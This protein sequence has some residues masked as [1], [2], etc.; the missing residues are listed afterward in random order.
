VA[1]RSKNI[2]GASKLAAE[3]LCRLAHRND[4][5]PCIILRTARFFPEEQDNA[6]MQSAYTT[7]NAQTIEYLHRRVDIED[8][9]SAHLL[10]AER[11]AE[12]GFGSYV[13]SATTPFRRDDLQDLAIDAAKV[14]RRYVAFDDTFAQ[15]GWT[16]YPAIDRVY[17]NHL[18]RAELGWRPIHDFATVLGRVRSGASPLSGL[19]RAVSVKGYHDTVFE[20]GPYPVDS[21]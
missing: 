12:I 10:A 1:P 5:L 20:S 18:A 13:I 14:V 4:K 16:M 19:A 6:A 3:D 9:V 11:A 15:R 8:V 2:Y 21:A 7:E 17:V